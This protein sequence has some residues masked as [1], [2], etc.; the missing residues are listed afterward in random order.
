MYS[1]NPGWDKSLFVKK[2][3]TSKTSKLS[4]NRGFLHD[5]IRNIEEN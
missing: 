3:K 1:N 4:Q 2:R 5:Q